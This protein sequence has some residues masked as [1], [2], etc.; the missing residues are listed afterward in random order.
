MNSSSTPVKWATMIPKIGGSAL[1]CYQ[2]TSTLPL[3]HLSYTTF[4]PNDS[5]LARYWPQVP[6][7]YLDQGEQSDKL[8]PVAQ[9]GEIDFVTAVCPCSGL[10]MLNTAS[11]GKVKYFVGQPW[12]SHTYLNP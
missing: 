6:F 4:Q 12:P 11:T 2:A 7:F 1:G 9:F 5:Q 10:S 8:I 3:Y